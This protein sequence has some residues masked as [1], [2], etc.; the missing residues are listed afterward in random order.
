MGVIRNHHNNINSDELDFL[1]NI[2]YYLNSSP[3]EQT[4]SN[5]DNTNNNDRDATLDMP[6]VVDI[7]NSTKQILIE[8]G[9]IDTLG[10][11]LMHLAG[12]FTAASLTEEVEEDTIAVGI[13]EY[14]NG[15]AE[16]EHIGGGRHSDLRHPLYLTVIFCIAY[17]LVFLV[18]FSGNMLTVA[19]VYRLPRMRTVTNFFIASL[20]VADILVLVICLPG[21]LMS[22]IFVRKYLLLLRYYH[23]VSIIQVDSLY[24]PLMYRSMS[25]FKKESNNI[26]YRQMNQHSQVIFCNLELKTLICCCTVSSV[27]FEAKRSLI[28]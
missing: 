19:V 22:N 24:P 3:P 23:I 10:N 21:T 12:N 17:V 15:S 7:Y 14:S 13:M 28:T 8:P 1:G 27:C 4:N 6:S 18:G 25:M 16:D 26:H 9:I 11:A 2:Q 20:A 5:S